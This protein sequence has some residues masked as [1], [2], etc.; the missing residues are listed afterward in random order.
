MP[1]RSYLRTDRT[2]RSSALSLTDEVRE[3]DDDEVTH[4]IFPGVRRHSKLNAS[5][6]AETLSAKVNT[7]ALQLKPC[8]IEL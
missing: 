3:P 7:D 5:A 2:D 6:Q 1:A 8:T 4:S